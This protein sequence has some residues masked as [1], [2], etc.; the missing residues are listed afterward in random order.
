MV[1]GQLQTLQLLKAEEKHS[2]FPE[3]MN[4]IISKK[5]PFSGLRQ[6]VV[7]K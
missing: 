5:D 6:W 7:S 3:P 2:Y 4:V 1:F